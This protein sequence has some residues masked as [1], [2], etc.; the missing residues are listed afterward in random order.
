MSQNFTRLHARVSFFYQTVV[1]HK[2]VPGLQL[3][4]SSRSKAHFVSATALRS[5]SSFGWS[6]MGPANVTGGVSGC[7]EPLAGSPGDWSKTGCTE[8]VKSEW[9]CDD[10]TQCQKTSTDVI[11][12]TFAAKIFTLGSNHRC[13]LCTSDVLKIDTCQGNGKEGQ[14]IICKNYLSNKYCNSYCQTLCKRWS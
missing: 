10:I 9:H 12:T 7:R 2:T 3:G 1:A 13:G 11:K 8:Y 14:Q 4:K 6:H 5:S